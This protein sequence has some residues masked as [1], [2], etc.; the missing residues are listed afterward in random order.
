MGDCAGA[1]GWFSCFS[2][3]GLP[4]GVLWPGWADVAEGFGLGFAVLAAG[5]AVLAAGFGGLPE[6]FAAGLGDLA[7][8]DLGAGGVSGFWVSGGAW[9]ALSSP[10]SAAG[11][12]AGVMR[13]PGT[14]SVAGG[15]SLGE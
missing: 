13:C 5:F 10:V 6:G 4:L 1:A 9:P 8:E 15:T 3:D 7:P 14:R 12:A 11:L 2:F